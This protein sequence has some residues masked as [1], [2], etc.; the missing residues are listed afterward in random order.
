MKLITVGYLLL[1]FGFIG[2]TK[3]QDDSLAGSFLSGKKFAFFF[4]ESTYTYIVIRN[5]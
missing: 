4:K 3:A 5:D 1:L 2:R